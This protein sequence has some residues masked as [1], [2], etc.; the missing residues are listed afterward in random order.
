MDFY[1][2]MQRT[3]PL[4]KLMN[5]TKKGKRGYL[6]E[7]DLNYPKELHENHN[8]V[9]SLVEKMKIGREEKLIPN[10]KCKKVY[11]VHINMTRVCC[12][13]G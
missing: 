4:K 2:K 6:L 9:P 12:L 11:V 1:G 5:L 7:V 8:E 10:L 3:L 13:K